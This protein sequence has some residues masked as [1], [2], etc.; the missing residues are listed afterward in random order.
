MLSKNVCRSKKYQPVCWDSSAAL[1][2]SNYSCPRFCRWHHVFHFSQLNHKD[3]ERSPCDG[4][5]NNCNYLM[6]FPSSLQLE[7]KPA[8][9]TFDLCKLSWNLI[10][11]TS[12]LDRGDQRGLLYS[13]NWRGNITLFLALLW[14][15]HCVCLK[16]LLSSFCLTSVSNNDTF[17][18][19]IL[20]LEERF[21]IY[22][23]TDVYQNF[24]VRTVWG[25]SD[26]VLS[27]LSMLTWLL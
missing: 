16:W 27:I 19:E 26:T 17:K 12:G 25:V 13:S 4:A 5:A 10:Q 14:A 11:K 2:G 15:R 6:W 8:L 9:A 21:W 20:L 24:K 23:A 22:Y 18:V 1:R 3:A 7:L